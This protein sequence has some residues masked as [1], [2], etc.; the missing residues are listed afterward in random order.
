MSDGWVNFDQI[1]PRYVSY[2]EFPRDE[3]LFPGN[4]TEHY[5]D[6]IVGW[7]L[8]VNTGTSARIVEAAKVPQL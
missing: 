1:F 3:S 8:V 2:E 5:P 4:T 7:F 6:Y